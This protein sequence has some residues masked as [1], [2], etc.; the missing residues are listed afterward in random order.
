MRTVDDDVV[1]VLIVCEDITQRKH[2]E[3]SLRASEARFRTLVGRLRVPG[4]LGRS[5]PSYGSSSAQTYVKIR[6]GSSLAATSSKIR[7]RNSPTS[8]LNGAEPKG[9]NCNAG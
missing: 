3:E 8:L 7:R 6:P 5:K 4:A 1:V 2:I 9:K